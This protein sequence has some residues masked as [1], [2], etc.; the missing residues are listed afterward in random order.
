MERSIEPLRIVPLR[1]EHRV[2]VRE[3]SAEVFA[4]FGDYEMLLPH[5][6][7]L[8]SVATFVAEVEGRPAGFAMLT[9]DARLAGE[10]ELSAIAV[11][12]ELQRRGI[13]RRL[14]QRVE[15]EALARCAGP[16]PPAIS[17]AVAEDNPAARRLFES[18]GYRVVPGGE[19]SY[20]RGQ[21][22]LT[23]RKVL[24]GGP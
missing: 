12:P 17:L 18:A 21:P 8:S 6:A 19:D 7:G 16:T 3:L 9:L 5:L 23:L 4:R 24:R 20:P 2:F 15:A 13:A 1:E 11:V 10:M 22:S 14:V